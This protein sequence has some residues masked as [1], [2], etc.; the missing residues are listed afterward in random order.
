MS[1]YINQSYIDLKIEELYLAFE[2]QQKKQQEK[3]EQRELRAQQREEAKLKKEIEENQIQIHIECPEKPVMAEINIEQMN[4]A[5]GSIL[6]N[7][8][9]ALL[10]KLQ[11]QSFSPFIT[12]KL[13]ERGN[14]TVF[15]SIYD[16]GIGIEDSIKDKIFEP[17]FT[18][19]PSAEA[20]G[21]G[22]YLCREVILNHQGSILAKSEKD[23]Y[24]EF[25]ITIPIS[26]KRINNE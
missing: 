6:K 11:K 26:Q 3:E 16:N 17:F 7:S 14:N 25:L 10:R 4:K 12:I 13:E 20:A 22:L 19:K 8:I 5:L 24:T 21:V 18:T 2:Y 9:Y 23:S 1:V 15:I